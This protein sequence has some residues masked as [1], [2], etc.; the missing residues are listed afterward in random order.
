MSNTTKKYASL[1][2]LQTFL[3][4]LKNLFAAKTVVDE[5]SADVDNKADASHSHVISDVTDLQSNLDTINGT[6]AQ[7]SQVQMITSENS[8]TLSTLKIHR[9]SQEEYNQKVENGTIDENALY[10]T[11]EEEIDLSPYATVEQLNAKADLEHNH[12]DLYY[13]E[14]EVDTLLSSK[15]N[16]NHNHDSDYDT[17]GSADSALVSAKEYTDS[18][19]SGLSSAS[20]TH[21]DRYYTESEIDTKIDTIN[22][23]LS[24][25]LDSS[26]LSNYSTTEESQ[27]YTDNAVAQK[28]QV[29]I[30]TWE[31]DD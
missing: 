4:N 25:K 20:H 6:L 2:T 3:D 27:D 1:S 29:Q 28:S 11:P 15:S 7:K 5:L 14:S 23:S 26:A 16:S 31:A 12:D 8:E 22:T 18:A 19:V 21:D 10:L 13:T 17:K 24:S 30:I 9:V